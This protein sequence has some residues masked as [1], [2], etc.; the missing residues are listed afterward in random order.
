[1]MEICKAI[2]QLPGTGVKIYAVRPT[3]VVLIEEGLQ[4]P[5]IPSFDVVG[6]A[7]TES[8]WQYESDMV[9]K[10]GETVVAIVMF[11]VA[12]FAQLSAED[13]VNL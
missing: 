9:G 10:L 8:F 1:M 6:N 4:V 13:G 11:I 2:P 12:G 7:G 3:S 5:L